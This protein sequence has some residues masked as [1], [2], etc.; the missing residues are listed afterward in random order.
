MRKYRLILIG[1]AVMGA[2]TVSSCSKSWTCSCTSAQSGDYSYE[3]EESTKSEAQQVC[4]GTNSN[5]KSGPSTT[6]QADECRLE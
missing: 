1:F 2:F 6:T 5:F 3:I 4:E